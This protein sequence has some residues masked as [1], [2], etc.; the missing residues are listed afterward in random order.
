[1]NTVYHTDFVTGSQKYIKDKSVQLIISDS[2]Y[3]KVKGDFD[4]IWKT[5]EDYLK[6]V[7]K[8]AIECK[9]ILA[10]NGT[11]YWYGSAKNIAYC[12]VILDKYFHLENSLV[13][14]KNECQTMKGVND[15]RCFAPVTER[16]LMYSNE[17]LKTGLEEIYD[18]PD[19][20]L[21]I[22]KYMRLERDNL[23][24]SKNFVTV[25]SFNDFINKVTNTSSVVPRHYF[26]DSQYRFPTV[27]IYKKLQS[28]GFWQKEYE[29]L[30]KEY[31]ELRK[32]Y[33]ELRRPFNNFLGLYDVM[34]FS[35]E[36]HI[37]K[38]FD[39]DTKKP[40]TLTRALILTSSRKDD[41][42]CVP[43]AG[44]GTECAMTIKESRKYIA[45]EIE[46]KY[47][48]MSNKRGEKEKIIK[49]QELFYYEDLG[50]K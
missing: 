4:F 31:E 44:S 34:K 10:D 26:A 28:T 25:A 1:M 40:E 21:P 3:Y 33:E 14:E 36:T 29:E 50:E 22:K 27:E 19:C 30:R 18:N 8:W 23:M 38:N 9:R 17:V 32:E 49:S 41:L 13:W 47:C 43:F 12:Q 15:Y 7:E 20:F 5:R 46:K 48:D 45:F 24:R 11:L 16:I 35:Q 2:P 6:D 37:T 42:V 39:H